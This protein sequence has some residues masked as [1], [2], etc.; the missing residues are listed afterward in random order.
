MKRTN[1]TYG[2]LNS[3]LRSLGFTWR[4]VK[5]RVE[6]RLYEHKDSGASFMLPP[7]PDTDKVL[8][9]HLVGARTTLDRFGV[10][11]PEV[12]DAKL[13]Q[14]KLKKRVNAES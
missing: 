2:Q 8:E 4:V 9:H 6:T 10:A 11:E 12:F 7:F 3:V 5:N 14:C 1:V 13:R